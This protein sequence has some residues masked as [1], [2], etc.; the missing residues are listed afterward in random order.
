[1][2]NYSWGDR[3]V[4]PLLQPATKLEFFFRADKSTPVA[5]AGRRLILKQLKTI[6]P[7]DAADYPQSAPPPNSIQN[8]L[9]AT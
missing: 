5:I 7:P 1:M 9:V 2:V 3:G 6:Y 4:K 8:S